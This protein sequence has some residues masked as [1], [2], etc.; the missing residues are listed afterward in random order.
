MNPEERMTTYRPHQ[1][2]DIGFIRTLVVMT[3]NV[4]ASREMLWQLFKRDFLAAYKKSFI[5]YTW[6]VISPILGIVSWVFLQKTGILKP[7]FLGIPY[8]AYVLIG[9]TTWGLFMG[10]FTAAAATLNAGKALVLQI[11]YPHEALLIKQTAIQVAN[12]LFAFLV[13][14]V[15]ILCFQVVPSWKLILFPLVALPLFFMGSAIGLMVSML[16]VVAIDLQ[17]FVTMGIG[18]LMWATPVI[19]SRDVENEFVQFLIKWNPLTYLVCSARDIVLF[20]HLYD[21]FGYAVSTALAIVMFFVSLRLFYVS[22]SQLI[23]RMI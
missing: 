23:E 2:Q 22:E 19:Y 8:P 20:G 14:L 13:A 21:P 16:S 15:V 12:F 9:S 5:G 17:K 18:L 7:G 11:N 1:R 3:R 6:I 4:A 10:L